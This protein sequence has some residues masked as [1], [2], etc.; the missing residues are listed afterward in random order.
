VTRP[1]IVLPADFPARKAAQVVARLASESPLHAVAASFRI[2]SGNVRAIGEAAGLIYIADGRRRM[3]LPPSHVVRLPLPGWPAP[4]KPPVRKS[5]ADLAE[6]QYADPEIFFPRKG[7]HEES[8]QAKTI[9]MSCQVRQQCLE[10]GMVPIAADD[11]DRD[12]PWGIWGGLSL[13]ERKR[14]RDRQTA[15]RAAR[16]P[17]RRSA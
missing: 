1:D 4:P 3:I 15:G 14:R 7:H 5:W 12:L 2:T 17:A 8:V 10:A 11:P 13:Q 9:C 6:C 16:A